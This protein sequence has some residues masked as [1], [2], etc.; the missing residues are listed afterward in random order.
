MYCFVHA[1]PTRA[2]PTHEDGGASPSPFYFTVLIVYFLV[3]EI[4]F[5]FRAQLV[6]LSIE[7]EGS[8]HARSHCVA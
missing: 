8:V 3:I 4:K 2:T 6:I 5:V 7:T 1:A